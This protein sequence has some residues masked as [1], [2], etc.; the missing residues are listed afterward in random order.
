MFSKSAF[1]NLIRKELL[2]KPKNNY[3]IRSNI[4]INMAKSR[5]EYVK[6]F[7]SEDRLLL[8]CWIIV[9]IDGKGFHKFTEK[10]NFTK[11]NDERALNL[12]NQCAIKV[13]KE[14]K[15]ISISFGQ[16]D[17][18][19][20]IFRKDTQIYNRRASKIASYVNSL[21]SSSYVFY[22]NDYLPGEKLTYPPMF[23]A[24]VILLPSDQNLRDYLSWRQADVHVNNLY[25]TTFWKLVLESGLSNAEVRNNKLT[26]L[27]A[28]LTHLVLHIFYCFLFETLCN[29]FFPG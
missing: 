4:K 17:E 2:H 3:F 28:I 15:D 13:M 21:F 9:R 29:L 20:F 27:S 7:E 26:P 6:K 23:D 11:P 14:F 5:F 12:M 8:N 19:S 10:H 25:N 18:Y 16:S 22:W 1:V 24:R